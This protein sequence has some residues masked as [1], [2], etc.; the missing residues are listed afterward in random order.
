MPE[1]RRLARSNRLKMNDQRLDRIRTC[2]EMSLR[3]NNYYYYYL[4]R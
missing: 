1:A 2:G 4:V 3:Y